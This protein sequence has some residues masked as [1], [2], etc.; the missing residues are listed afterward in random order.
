M[1][2]IDFS[3]THLNVTIMPLSCSDNQLFMVLSIAC[4]LYN[5]FRESPRCIVHLAINLFTLRN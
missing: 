4:E 5:T 2:R 3:S 1:I